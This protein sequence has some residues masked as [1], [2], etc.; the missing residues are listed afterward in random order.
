MKAEF[1]QW[2]MSKSIEFIDQSA[3]ASDTFNTKGK[4]ITDTGKKGSS[5]NGTFYEL[6]KNGKTILLLEKISHL[7][8][9]KGRTPILTLMQWLLKNEAFA[10]SELIKT[11]MV[12]VAE[13]SVG[14]YSP[15]NDEWAVRPG[16]REESIVL[17]M[18]TKSAKKHING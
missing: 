11:N 6:S 14:Y 7:E 17:N 3:Y 2:K 5:L 12:H 13:Y 8:C 10:N 18:R 1:K 15:N 9:P 16:I 4:Y